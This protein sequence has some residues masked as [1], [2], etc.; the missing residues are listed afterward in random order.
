MTIVTLNC[1]RLVLQ[2]TVHG[3]KIH[4]YDCSWRNDGLENS[5]NKRLLFERAKKES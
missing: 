1:C 2:R 5:P 4:R 3:T